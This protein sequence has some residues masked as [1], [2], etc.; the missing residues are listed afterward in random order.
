MLNEDLQC[1]SL[2]CESRSLA[3][4]MNPLGGKP[5]FCIQC[6][7]TATASRCDCLAIV[8]IA[9]VAGGEHAIH[10]GVSALWGRPLDVTLVGE[11]KLA[12]EEIAKQ[13]R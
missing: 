8:I 6:C 1:F 12:A 7:H 13:I 9:D 5:T 10:A 4:L 11:D 3:L 2:H